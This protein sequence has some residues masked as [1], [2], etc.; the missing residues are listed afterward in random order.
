MDEDER[1]TILKCD[2]QRTTSTDD[3]YLR[4][5]LE[6]ARAAILREGI[7]APAAGGGVEVDMAVVSYAAY[8]FRKRA[9]DA[10]M[11]RYLRYML[12]NLLISQKGRP[13]G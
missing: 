13:D 2:L 7:A 12:N 9:S 10:P 5:L 8:L 1:L 4:V 3:D 6:Q 11:P